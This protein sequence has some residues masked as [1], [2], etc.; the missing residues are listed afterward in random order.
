MVN[1]AQYWLRPDIFVNFRHYVNPL[2]TYLILSLLLN[3]FS[4]F[5]TYF[6][7]NRPFLQTSK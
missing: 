3:L 1:L 2:L 4:Y 6:L 7:E 5:L